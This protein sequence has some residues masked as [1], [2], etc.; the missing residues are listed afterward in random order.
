[1]NGG[2]MRLLVGIVTFL[3]AGGL[4]CSYGQN[5]LNLWSTTPRILVVPVVVDF[6]RGTNLK[7][8]GDTLQ[9]KG[10]VDRSW[11]F[12]IWVKIFNDFRKFQAGSYQF[13]GFISPVGIVDKISTGETYQP[14]ALE[15]TIPEGFALKQVI[16]RLEARGVADANKLWEVATNKSLL[17]KYEL[18][19][20][21]A[22]GYFY[23]ATYQF[24]KPPTPEQ[25]FEQA[26]ETFRKKLP[27]NY[28]ARVIARGLTLHEAVTFASLIEQETLHADERPFVSEVIW[29][30]LAAKEPLAIDAALIYG[31][32]DYNGD[33]TRKHLQDPSNP[34]NTRIHQGLPPGPICSPSKD[35]LE[36]VLTPSDQGYYFY[37]LDPETGNRHHFS[38]TAEEHNRYV[39][40]LVE[41]Q[42]RRDRV[43]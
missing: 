36:A 43:G 39:R 4:L 22:E 17:K 23:P 5:R 14:I 21:S 13:E 24:E 3:V 10:V 42:K 20:S 6:P 37:V 25:V 11:L 1:M 32:T 15:Y 16:A 9:E 31:I 2:F 35:S 33:L 41:F 28:E 30:R 26:L 34:F 29:R 38:K 19:V 8:L 27:E 40:K 7:S 12:Q 18:N